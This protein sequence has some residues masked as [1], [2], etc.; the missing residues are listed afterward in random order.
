MCFFFFYGKG[1]KNH[2]LGTC[3]IVCKRIIAAVKRVGFVSDRMP[4]VILKVR[5]CHV[6]VLELSF[7]NRS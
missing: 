1:N 4:Y 3:F 7:S 2:E 6:I 5:W